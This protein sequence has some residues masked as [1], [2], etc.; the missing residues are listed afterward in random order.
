[1]IHEALKVLIIT[2]FAFG[3][4]IPKKKTASIEIHLYYSWEPS[5]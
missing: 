1:M 3:I 4:S 5:K 2:D